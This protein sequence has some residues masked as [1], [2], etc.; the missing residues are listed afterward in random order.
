M[1]SRFRG[2]QRALQILY[3][4]DVRKIPVEEAINT[5]FS[6][7]AVEEDEEVPERDDFSLDLAHG[8]TGNQKDIDE[9]IARHSEHWRLERMAV[10]DRNILRL[11]TFEMAFLKTPPPV[12]IDQA[13]ELARRF[14]SDES[15]AF[16]NGVL[17][18]I[19]QGLAEPAED[20]PGG[21]QQ[22]PD[23]G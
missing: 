2:R 7:L 17:D 15:V 16:L 22:A 23:P 11:A 14:S 8:T 10:V 4:W 20:P 9:R 13:L 6:P 3:L 12:V 19:R 1:P 18:S 21:R 5:Y